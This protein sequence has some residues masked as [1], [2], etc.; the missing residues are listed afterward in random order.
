MIYQQC[1]SLCPQTCDNRNET[2]EGGCAEGCFCPVGQVLVNGVC[3][4]ESLCTGT[5]ICTNIRCIIYI[6]CIYVYIPLLHLRS[7]ESQCIYIYIL[8]IYYT[9]IS[10]AQEC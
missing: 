9:H 6:I 8:Y 7:K 2:C 1:G 3:V 10:L 4:D 5:Y